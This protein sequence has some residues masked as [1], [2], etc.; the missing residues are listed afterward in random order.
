[1]ATRSK[2]NV[3]A[4]AMSP[5]AATPA[6]GTVN[7]KAAVGNAAGNTQQKG[8]GNAMQ[9]VPNTAENTVE[10]TKVDDSSILFNILFMQ[11]LLFLL[12]FLSKSSSSNLNYP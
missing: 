2:N 9:P 12:Q 6:A 4:K 8:L 7:A 3:Q 10:K 11:S 1:M 5:Q